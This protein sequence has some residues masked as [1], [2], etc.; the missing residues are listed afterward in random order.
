MMGRCRRAGRSPLRVSAAVVGLLLVL[1]VAGCTQAVAGRGGGRAGTAARAGGREHAAARDR[2]RRCPPTRSA[3]PPSTRCRSS[4]AAQFPAAF[5]RPWTDIAGFVPVRHD[6]AAAR[7]PPPC[8]RRAADLADQAFYC[9]S[10]DIVAWDADR[11]LPQ[12]VEKFGAAGAVVVLA[13]EVGHAVHNRLG[14]DAQRARN[15]ARYPT[16]LLEAMA[17]CYAGVALAHFVD[18][19]VDGLPIGLDER[20]QALLALV[21]FRDPLGVDAGR[22]ERARQRVRPGVGV[23]DR[24][25]GGRRPAAPG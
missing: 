1:L 18:Q 8:L 15:P 7:S 10:A 9:P 13:H 5:G 22:R 19:P 20:D 3:R 24:L 11:L 17:D 2:R 16:I 25:R 6:P 12:Q 21:G 14:I 23:P 4:G